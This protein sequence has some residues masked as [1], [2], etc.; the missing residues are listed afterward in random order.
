LRRSS[1]S[2]L[3]NL[4]WAA[5]G[6]S[7][8]ED[9]EEVIIGGLDGDV[10]LDQGLPLADK[11]SELVG[12]EVKTVE[13]GQAV[14]ALNLINTELDLAERVVLI[15]LEISQRNLEDATLE[16]VVRVLQTGGPVDKSLADTKAKLLD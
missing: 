12:G 13:V 6:E 2:G 10:G 3:L 1:I 5:L 15:L 4:V 14:L 7:D 9:A 8:G 11:G 16:C